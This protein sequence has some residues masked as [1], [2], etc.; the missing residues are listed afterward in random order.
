MLRLFDCFEELVGLHC[1]I[2]PHRIKN[3]FHIK[4]N[5]TE[6]N[7]NELRHVKS[8]HT[9]IPIISSLVSSHIAPSTTVAH[10]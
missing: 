1:D 2:I 3:S 4:L 6:S 5:N 9:S 7:Y 8:H 10:P